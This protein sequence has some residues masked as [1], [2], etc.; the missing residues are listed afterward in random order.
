MALESRA[1]FLPSFLLQQLTPASAVT[2]KSGTEYGRR[3]MRGRKRML[4]M[5]MLVNYR[6]LGEKKKSFLFFLHERNAT[7]HTRYKSGLNQVKL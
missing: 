3:K 6:K 7:N 2:R 4:M 5:I 1:T